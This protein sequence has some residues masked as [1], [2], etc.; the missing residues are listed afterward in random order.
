MTETP[1]RRQLGGTPFTIAP[2][3]F[4]GNVFGL[5]LIHI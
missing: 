4:G 5:S 3:M 2:L 1:E